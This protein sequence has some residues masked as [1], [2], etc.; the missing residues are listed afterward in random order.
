MSYEIPEPEPFNP[1]YR[2]NPVHPDEDYLDP[3]T[4]L[5]FEEQ[6][7]ERITYQTQY[8]PPAN[9]D[10]DIY[11]TKQTEQVEYADARTA[12]QANVSFILRFLFFY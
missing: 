7:E 8:L 5:P 2:L 3:N 6:T 12:S 10:R 11:V 1:H 4:G 9:N